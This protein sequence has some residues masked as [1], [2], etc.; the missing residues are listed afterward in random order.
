MFEG[1]S[2][3]DRLAHAEQFPRTRQAVRKCKIKFIDESIGFCFKKNY[4]LA[5]V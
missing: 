5:R 2:L 3:R 4:E 1:S